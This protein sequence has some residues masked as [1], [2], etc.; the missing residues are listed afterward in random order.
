MENSEPSWCIK[1]VDS[2]IPSSFQKK[3]K[4]NEEKMGI[5]YFWCNSKLITV[6]T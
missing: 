4:K 1:E 5:L 2:I 3:Q 6:D